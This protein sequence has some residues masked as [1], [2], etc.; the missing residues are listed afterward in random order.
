MQN[1]RQPF[2]DLRPLCKVFAPLVCLE[3]EDFRN[4][5]P[6]QS[7]ELLIHLKAFRRPGRPFYLLKG[8]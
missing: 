5:A 3:F 2:E 7:C 6:I 1:K 4:Q 8:H